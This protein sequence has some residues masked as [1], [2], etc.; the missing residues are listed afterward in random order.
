[1]PHITLGRFCKLTPNT[2]QKIKVIDWLSRVW[3]LWPKQF[4][5]QWHELKTLLQMGWC[6]KDKNLIIFTKYMGKF[7]EGVYILK[8]MGEMYIILYIYI[9][10][11]VK[12]LWFSMPTRGKGGNKA[13]RQQRR[14][15]RFRNWKNG[16]C[17]SK[18][19]SQQQT[20]PLSLT[21]MLR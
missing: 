2:R 14:T 6:W 17:G 16:M 7:I 12:M 1:M 20:C 3:K 21:R 15:K 13:K 11:K 8:Y 19:R 5:V 18:P 9:H 4:R 10:V